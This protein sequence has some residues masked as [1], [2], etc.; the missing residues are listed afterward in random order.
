MKNKLIIMAILAMLLSNVQNESTGEALVDWDKITEAVTESERKA[1]N[2]LEEE[3]K[4]DTEGDIESEE[5]DDDD[6]SEVELLRE[7][8]LDDE[9][10]GTAP[11]G[12]ALS[13]S[14]DTEEIEEDN[15]NTEEVSSSAE[16]DS[17]IKYY[18]DFLNGKIATEDGKTI[19]DYIEYAD[20][21]GY[22]YIRAKGAK[23][24]ALLIGYDVCGCHVDL[25]YY[26]NGKMVNKAYVGGT[27]AGDICLYDQTY[28]SDF[29]GLGS[30]ESV[31]Y[32]ISELDENY[33]L[34]LLKKLKENEEQCEYHKEYELASDYGV[35][36][37]EEY[38]QQYYN[39]NI[40]DYI[41]GMDESFTIISQK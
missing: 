31:S 35:S 18:E 37:G 14:D 32:D 33:N 15:V 25:Y 26:E 10:D 24:K 1:E 20:R 2:D 27:A 36:N 17:Y 8:I 22:R 34:K 7:L 39:A 5:N 38:L 13:T 6:M 11:E 3:R 23:H 41:S 16:E 21:V 9:E 4:E 12:E 40:D 30:C 28:I 29:Y 19:D